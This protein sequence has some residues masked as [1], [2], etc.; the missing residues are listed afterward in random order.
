MPKTKKLKNKEVAIAHIIN[1]IGITDYMETHKSELFY[2]GEFKEFFLDSI[3]RLIGFL[4]TEFK[5]KDEDFTAVVKS[6][7]KS[8]CSEVEIFDLADIKGNSFFVNID[9]NIEQ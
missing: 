1:L 9:K 3:E 6:I 2:D 7:A 5:V 8:L 4:N